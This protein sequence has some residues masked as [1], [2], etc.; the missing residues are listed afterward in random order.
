MEILK[1]KKAYFQY[2]IEDTYEAG[3]VLCGTEVKS[4]RSKKINF[5]DA[6]GVFKNHELF[7][8]NCRIEPY[9]HGTHSNHDP[10]RTRKL[11]LHRKELIKIK[12]KIT[13]KGYVCVPISCYFK[14]G[15]VKLSMGLGKGK[16]MHDKRETIKS[17]DIKRDMERERENY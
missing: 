1:N 11:L 2:Q 5:Q 10:I 7:L 12:N 3:I 15:K 6:Y 17:R 4:L 16:K 8:I 14:N 13:Q 9:S